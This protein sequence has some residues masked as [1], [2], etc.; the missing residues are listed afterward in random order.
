MQMQVV[1]KNVVGLLPGRTRPD[2]T[3]FYTAHWDHLGVG[4]PDAN[5]DAIYNGAQDNGTGIAA[6]LELARVFAAGDRPERSVV[7]LFVT[8]EEKGLLGSLYYGEHPLYPLAKTVAVYNMDG[9][10]TA[11]P[12][13]DISVRGGGQVSL[14]DD[15]A[16]GARAQSRRL[17][18]D[19]RP[20]AGY[21]YR[22]D[23]FSFARVG[24]PAISVES[25]EDLVEGGTAAG[26]AADE[27]YTAKRYHQPDDEWTATMDLRGLAQDTELVYALGRD[28]AN[29]ARWP[30]W[31]EGSEFKAVR[32]QTADQRR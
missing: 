13:Q 12:A 20:E 6:L 14:E 9:L 24:V 28:M 15:V 3:I 18:P 25:G 29:S 19:P 32:D 17:S 2:E 21:F 22:S 1:S 11:G 30:G 26:R 23:H 8:A 5:G 4:T 27:D 10:A 16:E 31:K 7:F